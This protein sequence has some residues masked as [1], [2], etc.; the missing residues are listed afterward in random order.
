MVL[1]MQDF[2]RP[3]VHINTVPV[4]ALEEVKDWLDSCDIPFTEGP[5]N[6]NWGQIVG[7]AGSTVDVLLTP[8][9]R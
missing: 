4:G 6:L 2:K 1:V 3:P 8:S 7:I 9:R 5:L